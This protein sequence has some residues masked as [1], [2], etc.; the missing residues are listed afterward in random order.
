MCLTTL[1][2]CVCTLECNKVTLNHGP[3]KQDLQ[4]CFE[5]ITNRP[6]T[7]PGTRELLYV[8]QTGV[9]EGNLALVSGHRPIIHIY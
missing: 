3:Q 7:C 6:T 4:D 2:T 9:T 1:E 8:I 5:K